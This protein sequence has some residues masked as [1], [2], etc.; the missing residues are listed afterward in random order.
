MPM[1]KPNCIC[2]D[3]ENYSIPFKE[4]IHHANLFLSIFQLIRF[5][6]HL[7]LILNALIWRFIAP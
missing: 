4:S 3:N 1:N 5:K 6:P 2:L 7:Y